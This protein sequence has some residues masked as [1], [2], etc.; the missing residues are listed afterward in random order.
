MVG[1]E[2]LT[3]PQPHLTSPHLYEALPVQGQESPA[4]LVFKYCMSKCNA[5]NHQNAFVGIHCPKQDSF[6]K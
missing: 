2:S 1:E 4:A 6:E 5:S 3:H